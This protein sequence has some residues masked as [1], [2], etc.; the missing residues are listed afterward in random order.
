VA[1]A[2]DAAEAAAPGSPYPREGLARLE[3]IGRAAETRGDERTAVHAWGAMR[4]AATATS[5][6]LGPSAAWVTLADEGVVR[7]GARPLVPSP[8]VHAREATLR[9]ALGHE[10]APSV[11]MLVL[12]GVGGLAF[13]AGCA[14]IA[15][16]ARDAD[17]LRRERWA[18]AAAGLGA[19]IYAVACLRA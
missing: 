11:A 3:A 1:R 8:E 12:L 15:V 2:R 16:A 7:A 10:D 14:R 17:A 13:F 18:I 6:V 4:A 19:L 5:G 9:A